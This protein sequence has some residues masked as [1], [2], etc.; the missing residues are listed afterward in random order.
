MRT[1]SFS[2][3]LGVILSSIRLRVCSL[4][5]VHDRPSF[6]KK[7]SQN[8][9]QHESLRRLLVR[10]GLLFFLINRMTSF[11]Y[12]GV[13][14]FQGCVYHAP[15]PQK[16]ANF[17]FGSLRDML[18]T[19]TQPSPLSLPFF[20]ARHSFFSVGGISLS[21]PNFLFFSFATGSPLS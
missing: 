14:F 20:F 19:F 9:L 21:R 17:C 3:S 8:V 12:R 5:G 7:C 4:S 1:N 10:M 18:K 6:P 13:F 16:V 15:P 2:S 11:R